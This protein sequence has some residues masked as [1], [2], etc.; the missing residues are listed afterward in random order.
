MGL[1][2]GETN[3]SF[4]TRIRRTRWVGRRRR[5]GWSC[6]PPRTAAGQKLHFALIGLSSGVGTLGRFRARLRRF[7]AELPKNQGSAKMAGSGGGVV[8]M[9]RLAL[10][11]AA[12]CERKKKRA[13]KNWT[14]TRSSTTCLYMGFRVRV[15][16]VASNHKIREQVRSCVRFS[17]LTCV[18]HPSNTIGF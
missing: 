2:G 13:S 16:K 12:G 10:L 6:V 17:C 14:L 11:L 1:G 7:R 5:W 3:V 4:R 9:C 18:A 8:P 15:R